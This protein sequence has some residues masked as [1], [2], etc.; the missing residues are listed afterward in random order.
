MI[1]YLNGK[2]AHK[3]PNY[4]IVECHG[5]GYHVRIS[6]NTYSNLGKDE[7]IK[8][9]TH[10]MIKDDAHELFGFLQPSEKVLFRQLIGISGVGG[11]TALTILSSISPKEL[12]QVIESE[13]VAML[14][15]VKGIGAKTAGRIILEL[16]GKLVTEGAAEAAG[17][18]VN[19]LRDEAIAGLVGLGLPKAMMEKRVDAL[20]KKAEGELTVA[21]IIRDALR[22]G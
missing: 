17:Q 2:L 15:K 3:D 1:A 10:L 6:L 14:K 21:D 19:K 7:H 18:P 9:H 8:L 12:Y 22:Q 11:V 4:V 13:D 20:I 5:V 16:K